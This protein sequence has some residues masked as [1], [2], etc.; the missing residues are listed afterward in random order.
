M[1]TLLA[2]L[3]LELPLAAKLFGPPEYPLKKILLR[4]S[5][6]KT[7]PTE[8]EEIKNSYG[9]HRLYQLLWLGRPP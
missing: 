6:S 2:L 8:A 7:P 1:L 5:R 9:Q 4:L 3:G